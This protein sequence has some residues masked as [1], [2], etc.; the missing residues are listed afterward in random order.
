MNINQIRIHDV[1][2]SYRH[3][4]GHD[5]FM[6]SNPLSLMMPGHVDQGPVPD[7]YPPFGEGTILTFEAEELRRSGN[8][9]ARRI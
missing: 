4:T 5:E 6:I 9:S 3:K 2:E 7:V 8:L 1:S